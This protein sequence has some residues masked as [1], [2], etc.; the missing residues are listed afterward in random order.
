MNDQL[1]R[2]LRHHFDA[3]TSHLPTS[4]PGLPEAGTIRHETTAPEPR[5]SP[6]MVAAAA[7]IVA[8]AVGGL[9]V[10]AGRSGNDDIATLDGGPIAPGETLEPAAT[11]PNTGDVSSAPVT[12]AATEPVDWYRFGPDLD[13][14]WFQDPASDAPSM[15]CWRTPAVPEGECTVDAIGTLVVPLVVPGGGSQTLVLAGGDR[16]EPTVQ[17]TLDDGSTLSAPQSFDDTIDWGIARLE[18]AAERSITLV[19]GEEVATR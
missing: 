8:L 4:G 5:R 18:L 9:L 6:W 7:S 3:R 12:V 11:L 13:V 17:V 10:V 1:E 16:S 19:N 2:E 14:A 15:F